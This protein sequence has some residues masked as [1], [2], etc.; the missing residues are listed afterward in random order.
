[1]DG[2]ARLLK[3]YGTRSFADVLARAIEYAEGGFIIAPRVAYDW[4]KLTEKLSFHAGAR[5][6]LL[7][8]G[9]PPKIGEKVRFPALGKTLRAIADKGRDAFYTGEIA[10]DMVAELR[11]LGGLHTV[12][13]FANQTSS[14]VEPIRVRY[15]GA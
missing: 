4:A 14:Y 11:E 7:P 3:D 8:N 12:E 9:R 6:H 5:Q 1:I 10:A 13:D 2:W 15:R